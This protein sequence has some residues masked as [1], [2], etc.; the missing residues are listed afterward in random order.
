VVD[1]CLLGQAAGR[2]PGVPDLDEQPLG[3]VEQRFLG[4]G[5]GGSRCEVCLSHTTKSFDQIDVELSR[6]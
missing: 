2:N 5:A 1:A 6:R 3:R 4:S